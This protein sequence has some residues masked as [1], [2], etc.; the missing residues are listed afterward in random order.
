VRR[1]R[2]H[3]NPLDLDRDRAARL[4]N[5]NQIDVARRLS[6]VPHD[7]R[8]DHAGLDVGV[9]GYPEFF[10]EQFAG[11]RKRD[12]PVDDLALGPIRDLLVR[13]GAGAVKERN[14][15][16]EAGAGRR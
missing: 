16:I 3:T 9:C 6:P 8:L 12:Q 5:H 2:E 4:G 7:E 1:L 10:Q 11:R 14:P 15:L 13:L